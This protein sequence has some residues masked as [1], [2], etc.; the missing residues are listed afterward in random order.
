MPKDTETEHYC[1]KCNR[2]TSNGHWLY[3]WEGKQGFACDDCGALIHSIGYYLLEKA[4]ELY[5]KHGIMMGAIKEKFGRFE[6]YAYPETEEQR[7][8]IKA[9]QEFYEKQYPEFTWEI[10]S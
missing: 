2:E 8:I 4:A 5:K 6:I 10:D 7:R 3:L 1:L 9:T